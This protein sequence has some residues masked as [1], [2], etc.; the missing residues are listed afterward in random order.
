M[1]LKRISILILALLTVF[2]CGCVSEDPIENLSQS[3]AETISE[4]LAESSLA[5]ELP[6]PTESDEESSGSGEIELP[7][8]TVVS[9]LACGDNLIHP[10]V[11]YGAMKYYADANGTTVDLK[12][13]PNNDMDYDFLPIYQRVADRMKNADICYI[14]Q[15]TLSGGP[16][17]KVDGYPMFNTPIA[18][19]RDL[20]ALGVDIVNMAHNHMVDSGSDSLLKYS[21][22]YF[23]SLGMTPLGYYENEADTNNITKRD[24][25]FFISA[26]FIG[27]LVFLLLS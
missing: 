3:I 13:W 17:T 24:V 5:T 25:S 10:S 26:N 19:G 14:N 18:M 12:T 23:E 21:D 16:G 6:L 20:A 9:F 27:L 8:D 4:D 7:T 15:E 22:P 11:F 2:V 1:S